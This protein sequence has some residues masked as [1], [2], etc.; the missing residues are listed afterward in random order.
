MQIKPAHMIKEKL[1]LSD[2]VLKT[3]VFN[4]LSDFMNFLM[5]PLLLLVL[6]AGLESDFVDKIVVFKVEGKRWG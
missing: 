1:K 5:N 2:K 3:L 6:C 4:T